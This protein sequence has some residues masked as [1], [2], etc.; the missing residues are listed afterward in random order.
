MERHLAHEVDALHHHPRDPEE[1]DVEAGDQ[2]I[3]GVVARQL[4]GLLRPAQC[5]K[6]PQRRTEPGVQHVL[7]LRQLRIG[8]V[9]RTRQRLGLRRTLRDE[10]AAVG[11]VP[12]GDLMAPPELARNAPGLDV[13]HPGEERVL[14][15]LRHEH[16]LAGL[17]RL[18]RRLRQHFSVAVPLHRQQRLDRHAA[19]IAVRH[20]MRVSLRLRQQAEPL[21][22]RHN[23]LARCASVHAVERAHEGRIGRA[24]H[25]PQHIGDLRQRHACLPIEDRRHRQPMPLRD[26]EVVEVM[27]R[28]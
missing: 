8:A 22:L 17:H 15:L 9:L 4:L 1:D 18:D 27:R 21:E 24:I 12:A 10:L 19:A 2:H 7:V 6:W 23:R 20:L 28:A 26:G 14:P 13:A 25:G 3:A 5:G 16:C 11:A